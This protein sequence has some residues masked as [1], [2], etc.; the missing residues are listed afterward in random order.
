MTDGRQITKSFN[1]R[2]QKIFQEFFYNWVFSTEMS[3][4]EIIDRYFTENFS[5][6]I[7]GKELGRDDFLHRIQRMRQE[8]VVEKQE[9][10]EMME[11]GDKLFSMHTVMGKS[12]ASGQPFKTRA[13]ALFVFKDSKIE[14]GY[15]NSATQGDPRDS[16]IASRS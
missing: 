11:E 1:G 15:L 10:I 13:I 5:A 7:D 8:A 4:R 9:F 16:D 6:L 3:D 12:L 2:L 14:E